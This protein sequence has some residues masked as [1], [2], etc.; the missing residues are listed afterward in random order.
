MHL[1]FATSIVPSGTPS[2]GYEIA[3][4]AIIDALRRAGV[5]VTVLGYTWPGVQPSDP[6]N[7]LVLGEVDV[8]TVEVT[9]LGEQGV[10]E[11]LVRRFARGALRG[12]V[13]GRP[14]LSGRP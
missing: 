12:V 11:V 8:R 2:T 13:H 1:V 5:R 6:D 14:V 3:N 10:V 7:T 9:F 4:A